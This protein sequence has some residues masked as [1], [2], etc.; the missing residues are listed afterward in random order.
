MTRTRTSA[1]IGTLFAALA[2]AVLLNAAAPA[3]AQTTVRFGTAGALSDGSLPVSTA[4]NNGGYA[5]AGLTPEVIHFKGGAPAIQAVVA[6]AIQFCICAPEHVVRLRSRGVDA[7]VAAPLTHKTAYVMA[8]PIG[9][10]IAGIADLKGKKVGITSPGSLTDN[11]IR[12]ELRRAGL[13]PDREVEIIGLGPSNNQIAALRIKQITAGMISGLEALDLE[14]YGLAPVVDW[15]ERV[16][17]SLALIARESWLKQN[18]AVAQAVI[19]ETLKATQLVLR[20]PA[21]LRKQL[22][23]VYPTIDDRVLERGV[24]YLQGALTS[25]PRFT[26]ESWNTLLRDILELEPDVKPLPFE[27]GNPSRIAS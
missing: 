12:L 19:G 16:I 4:I 25:T 26:P 21:E 18:P 13:V 3:G 14:S 9:A 24:K 10:G 6:G 17:P 27:T 5:A 8:A 2:G 1:R 7:V 23:A 20:D 15:R 11:L 22:R